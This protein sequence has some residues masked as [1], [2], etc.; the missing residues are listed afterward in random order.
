VENFLAVVEGLKAGGPYAFLALVGWAYVR[1][2]ANN[3]ELYM[4]VIEMAQQMATSNV[5]LKAAM[6]ALKD[7]MNTLANRLP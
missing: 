6:T 5:E 7:A 1:E 4:K 2:R 3:K